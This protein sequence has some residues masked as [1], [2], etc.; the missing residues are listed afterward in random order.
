[1]HAELLRKLQLHGLLNL[2]LDVSLAN[3]NFKNVFSVGISIVNRVAF[4]ALSLEDFC[5][6]AVVIQIL[7]YSFFIAS[8]F[9]FRLRSNFH[10]G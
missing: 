10:N 4:E 6:E 8:L 2:L 5:T 7:G 9:L 3:H 1:M